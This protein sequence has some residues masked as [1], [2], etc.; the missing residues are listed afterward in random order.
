[1]NDSLKRL[2]RIGILAAVAALPMA[3]S[4]VTPITSIQAHYDSLDDPTNDFTANGGGTGAFPTGTVYSTTFTDGQFDNLIIDGFDVGTNNFIFRQLAER[5]NVVRVNNSS[6]T[7]QHQILLYDQ[8][9]PIQNVT[10]ISLSS[11]YAANMEEI[12]LATIINRGVDNVFC[13]TG[14]GDGNNNN[15]ERIDYI[16]RDGY[17][18]FGN[19]RKKGF[20]I[21]DRGGNDACWIAAILALD[22]NGMPLTFSPPVLLAQTNW[23]ASG[24][25]LDTI[26]YRGY[27]EDFRPSADVGPQPLTGQYVEWEEFGITPNTLV[28]GY[29]LAA[30]D[31]PATQNWHDVAN[32]PLNTTEGST[33]GGLDLMSGGALILDERQNATLGDRVWNDLNQNGLQDAGEPGVSN[34]LVRAWDST[35]TN[36]AGQARTEDDGSY[37]IFALEPN[38]YQFEVVPPT[39]WIITAQ[40]IG[41]DDTIDSDVNTNTG[42]SGFVQLFPSQTNRW[43]DAGIFLPPTDLGVTKAV[44]DATPRVGTNIV[45]TITVTNRGP[46][47]VGS[48][49]ISDLLPAGLTFSNANTTLGAYTASN[50]IWS[51]GFLNTGA[52]ARLVVT[53]SVDLA[54]GGFILTNTAA[55]SFADRPDTNLLNNSASVTVAVRSVDLSVTKTVS[56]PQPGVSELISYRVTVTNFGPHT[57]FG[58]TLTDLIP[59]GLTFS[60]ASPSVGTYTASNGLWNI[61]TMTNRAFASLVLTARVNSASAGLVITNTA[62]A[63]TLGTGDTNAANDSASAIITVLGADVGLTKTADPLVVFPGSNV[64]YTLMLS[65]AGPTIATGLTVT[66][67]LTNGLSFVSSTASS[68]TYN[69]VSGIWTV[70]TLTAGS[71]AT[72]QITATAATNTINSLLTNRAVITNNDI[73]DGNTANNTGTAVVAVSALRIIKSSSVVSNVFPGSNIT[74]TIIVTNAG[75]HGHTNI[76]VTDYI[77][78]GTVYVANS[79]QITGPIIATNDVLDRWET[80]SF[81]NN[82]GTTNWT[83][84]WIEIGEADGAAASDVRQIT[85]GTNRVLQLQD[86]DNGGEGVRRQVNLGGR[87]VASLSF[88]YRR[89]GLDGSSDYVAVSVSS[90]GGTSWIELDRI[91]GPNNDTTYQ[92]AE[93]DISS[94]I[95]TNTQVRFLTSPTMGGTDIVYFDN[96]RVGWPV[97]GTNTV[98][99]GTPP[100]LAT[101]WTLEAGQFLTITFQATVNNPVAVTQI[102][103]TAFATSDSLPLPVSSTVRDPIVDTD[104]A[105]F[106]SVNNTNPSSGALIAYTIT[107]TNRGPRT[108]SSVTVTELLT[109]GLSYASFSATRGTFST[110]TGV[111]TVGVLTNNTAA[112]LVLTAR[113]SSLSQYVGQ[114]LTNIV[115][116]TGS[117]LA[118]TVPTNNTASASITVGAAD[119][120]VTK[121][122]DDDSPLRGSNIVYS[123]LVSN[124]GPTLASSVQITDVLPAGLRYLSY[125]ASQG[126][127]AT[128]TGIWS[129]GTINAEGTATLT[130]NA[131]VTTLVVG[132]YITNRAFVSSMTQPDP[133]TTNNTGTVVIIT[134]AQ[135][136]LQI[137]KTSS[138]GGSATNIG[139]APPGFTNVY[140][141]IVTNPNSFF[142][143]G[144]NV[145]DPVPTGMTFVPSSTIIESPEYY[146]FWWLDEFYSRFYNNN[147]GPTNFLTNWDESESGDDPLAGNVQIA[148]DYL[149][150]VTYTLQ[151]QG[152]NVTQSIQRS[153]SLGGFTNGIYSFRYRRESLEAGDFVLAQISS[154]NLAGPWSTLLRIE[155]PADDLTY[156][157]TNFDIRPWIS[158]NVTIRFVTTNTAMGAGDI[159][160]IDDVRIDASRDSYSAR[161]GGLPPVVATNLYL[162][163]G[164]YARITYQAVVDNP[165]LVTQVVNTASVTS[166]QQIVSLSVAVTDRVEVADI[167]LGK[168]AAFS[169][170]DEGGT[171]V[172]TITLTNF[173]PY[174]ASGI[175]IADLLPTNM[176]YTGYGASTGIYSNVSGIWTIATLNVSNVAT[177]TLTGTV[178]TGTTGLIITNT[179]SVASLVQSDRNPTNDRASASF[180]VEFTDLALGK[181]AQFAIRDEGQTQVFFV[182]V[183]NLGPTLATNVTVQDL[184]PTGVTY[185]GYSSSTGAYSAVSGIWTVGT[186][187]IGGTA[188]LT[189]TS[190]V[191]TGT[192]GRTI[193]NRATVLTS[194]PADR[195]PTNSTAIATFRVE[196]ADLGIGKSAT[197]PVRDE[198]Q[199]QVFIVTITNLGPYL[200]TN[201]TVRDVLPPGVTFVGYGASTGVYSN[202]SGIW[203]VGTLAVSNVASLVITSTVNA[204]T[205]GTTITNTADVLSSS[206]NDRFTNNNSASATFRVEFT[207]LGLTKAVN[208]PMP[209]EASPVV[210][211]IILT[212]L[213]PA[214][215]TG[216]RVTDLLP[217]TVTMVSNAPSV[218]TFTL[219]NGLWNVGALGL[220]TTATLLV[221]ATVNLGTAGFAITNTAAITA[222]DQPDRNLTNNTA[223]VTNRVVPPFVIT[224][225]R[226]VT[227]NGAV[228]VQHTIVNPQQVYDLL[229][230]DAPSFHEGLSNTWQLADR[231]AG[232]LLI[233]TGAVSRVSPKDMPQGWLRFYRI[234][235]AGFWEGNP[236]RGSAQVLAFGVAHI[237]PGQ[238]W[239]RPWGVPCNNAISEILGRHLPAG[240]TPV[241]ATKVMWFNRLPKPVPCTQMVFLVSGAT[242]R[243]MCSIPTNR[244]GYWADSYQLPLENGFYVDLPTNQTLKKIPM[245]F[246]VPTNPVIQLIKGGTATNFHF[247]S[248]NLPMRTHPSE[249]NLLSAGFTGGI[250]PIQSDWMWKYDRANQRVPD[251]IWYRTTDQTWRFLSTGYP[252]VPAGYF[253]YDDAIVIQ[254]RKSQSTLNWTNTVPYKAPTREMN[255]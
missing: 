85:D 173:G 212:N 238:N 16:F 195:N 17:P 2:V 168:S 188:S 117:S 151:F 1:M 104:L 3:A 23:G 66:E 42:R 31:V 6:V 224:D 192:T 225:C 172:F 53:A 241:N 118:D 243:W 19:L 176:T 196:H 50:G 129:V 169:S 184:L 235:A 210:Y 126:T 72:L 38:L 5:I 187:S 191:S 157:S 75:S 165:A 137:F 128:N 33:A 44:N 107:I 215:A 125:S 47:S 102:V 251:K 182:V 79:A 67:R 60:N 148:Y 68:G 21:M 166:D 123:I 63:N 58:V 90:N 24:I 65:N 25:T 209:D 39:N 193:T 149:N 219:S 37:F 178:N 189:I 247:V 99:G 216:V 223:S 171:Q 142:H 181:S 244:A 61:G 130:L 12:L 70:G 114:T 122:V 14:N 74:Y 254:T 239:V 93:F 22:T 76:V 7:G 101:N 103:N 143:T 55:I 175:R 98:A 197:F 204:G 249:M 109:N 228:E 57:A 231:R 10:N 69:N 116:I 82:N 80:A 86:N 217:S 153:F 162:R 240:D 119:L 112:T 229:Y 45:F 135:D 35:G 18:A 36:L 214:A 20:M 62:T 27:D 234:S 183:T 248:I 96:I 13:N 211:T 49:A 253:G 40:D 252:A 133:V 73:P 236:R 52:W 29:S 32:F 131:S 245:I 132:A 186:L 100:N 206:H 8:E 201:V 139:Q 199:T 147:H 92:F 71:F 59:A 134:T 87:T 250:N 26:V 194:T 4:A 15:I 77:P 205:V 154:N 91:E 185:V 46:W 56:N 34:V 48:V 232:G 144:I 167:G 88:N 203:T 140:T 207:D 190:L 208:D 78:T 105:I 155:G 177:L 83:G 170:L 180:R 30:A 51:V 41:P 158:S 146:D 221:Y 113:V 218:G 156:A 255:P 106:K 111:W 81:G 28:F 120:A 222:A 152:A 138:A 163:P 161:P 179:A 233:D 174:R 115:S 136:P 164:D 237:Y 108:A 141:I 124:I 226:Y 220:N 160:W 84:N 213:G 121:T 227:S 54:S 145:I 11:Q 230:T 94:Y 95:A 202:V 9:G 97:G 110:N 89:S 150:G 198:G 159:V 246:H 43:M 64:V 200:A 242:N 127:Y